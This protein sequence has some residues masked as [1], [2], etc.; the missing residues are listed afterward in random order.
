[1][2]FVYRILLTINATSLLII[3]YFVKM[4]KTPYWASY[5]PDIIVSSGVF[6]II[7]L[8][9]VL[10]FTALLILIS[11]FLPQDEFRVGDIVELE[12]AA[13]SFLPSYLG[14]F[15]V[16]LSIPNFPTLFFVYAIL[17]AFTFKSQ[18]LYFNPVFL[19]F[20][21]SFYTVKTNKG[22]MLFFISR[23]VYRNPSELR[24]IKA[25]RINDFTFLEI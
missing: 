23:N 11:C 25:A 17:F 1:M 4:D 6:Y 13:N 18:A 21:Y 15:F 19:L 3:V 22:V 7:Y 12:Q 14:Y 9:P 24:I 2:D 8:A 10:I 16:A 5:L 20:G